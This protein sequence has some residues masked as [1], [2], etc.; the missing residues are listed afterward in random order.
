MLKRKHF[1]PVGILIALVLILQGCSSTTSTPES[2]DTITFGTLLMQDDLAFELDFSHDS[3]T[4]TTDA[5]LEYDS[6]F[7]A[8]NSFAHKDTLSVESQVFYNAILYMYDN[9]YTA[10]CVDFDTTYTGSVMEDILMKVA[11]DDPSIPFNL[12][13]E[14]HENYVCVDTGA[15]NTSHYN[16]LALDEATAIL[17]EI[18]PENAN[19]VEIAKLIYSYL[20]KT[21]T[22]TTDIDK[23]NTTFLYSALIEKRTNCDGFSNAYSL[24]CNMA[25]V[26]CYEVAYTDD[27]LSDYYTA[28]NIEKDNEDVSGHIWNMV[29]LNAGYTFVD[30]SAAS[31][32]YELSETVENIYFAFDGTRSV[33]IIPIFMLN[34]ATVKLNSSDFLFLDNETTDDDFASMKQKLYDD[35]YLIFFL[36][37]SIDRNA[38]VGEHFVPETDFAFYRFIRTQKINDIERNLIILYKNQ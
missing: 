2:T 15:I 8:Y 7:G 29:N 6:R 32:L 9:E 14:I 30:V 24:L 34:N 22:Y 21:V 3:I 16:E 33:N 37:A 27:A 35:G 36:D 26:K 1:I 19:E 25:G 4:L 38:F 11:L 13:Y 10:F 5:L 23:N 28:L 17:D 12:S 20:T 18:L 31:Q